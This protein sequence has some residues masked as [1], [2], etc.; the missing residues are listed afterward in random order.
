MQESR[1]QLYGICIDLKKS[2]MGADKAEFQT[3]Q[4][5]SVVTKLFIAVKEKLKDWLQIEVHVR[6][7]LPCYHASEVRVLSYALIRVS[8]AQHRQRK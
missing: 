6:L 1:K 5:A 3:A 4:E 7:G 2:V 8:D